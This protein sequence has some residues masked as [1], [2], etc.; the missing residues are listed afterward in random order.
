MLSSGPLSC[1]TF[2]FERLERM[3]DIQAD[4]VTGDGGEWLSIEEAATRL[5]VSDRTI[6]RRIAAQEYPAR[7]EALPGG[8]R[9]R[10]VQLPASG[11]TGEDTR[12]TV[13]GDAK[14]SERDKRD[15]PPSV[16][17]SSSVTSDNARATSAR[18]AEDKRDT[19]E[20]DTQEPRVA[21]LERELKAAREEAERLKAERDRERE[22]VLFLRDR[23]TELNAMVMQTARALPAQASEPRVI[24]APELGTG[25]P[26]VV[27][28][29]MPSESRP[30]IK[31]PQRKP[32]PFWAVFLGIRRK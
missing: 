29:Q 9:R 5:Q 19:G 10:L 12:A 4:N 28:S 17:A 16:S 23:V 30:G 18:D 24:D 27:S 7:F 11:T 21:T 22:E 6:K 8:G 2:L 3:S 20:S 26:P 14:D 13:T 32:R 15:T 25:T 1:S 31:R